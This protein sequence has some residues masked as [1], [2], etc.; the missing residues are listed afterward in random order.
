MKGIKISDL[1]K[2][3]Y[4]EIEKIDLVNNKKQALF[5]N[6]ASFVIILL[7]VSQF[8]GLRILSRSSSLAFRLV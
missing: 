6:I 7:T 1:D 2:L 3:S 4:R 5:V 8:I